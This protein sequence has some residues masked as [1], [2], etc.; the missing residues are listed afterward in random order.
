MGKVTAM[1]SVHILRTQ[2]KGGSKFNGNW[3]F[4]ADSVSW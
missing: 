4:G 3:A 2:V 1:V